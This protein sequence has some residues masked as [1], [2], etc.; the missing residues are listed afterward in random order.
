MIALRGASNYD[1]ITFQS[2]EANP[3]TGAANTTHIEITAMSENVTIYGA[4]SCNWWQPPVNH[5]AIVSNVSTNVN[6][7]G[8]RSRGSP[9]AAVLQ[10]EPQGF[11][12]SR[13]TQTDGWWALL[14]DLEIPTGIARNISS[15][16]L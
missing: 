5:L 16:S 2:E 12:P 13:L 7:I 4:L 8:L 10:P 15:L 6:I 14:V 11:G 9:N 3:I 1:L